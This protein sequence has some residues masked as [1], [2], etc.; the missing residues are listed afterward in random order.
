MNSECEKR[1]VEGFMQR[2]N[3][4][5]F[6]CCYRRRRA[7]ENTEQQEEGITTQTKNLAMVGGS[8]STFFSTGQTSLRQQAVFM[9]ICVDQVREEV[10]NEGLCCFGVQS[11]DY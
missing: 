3:D 11:I 8:G 2:E 7:R 4:R 6:Q 5:G 10:E 9:W 1:D